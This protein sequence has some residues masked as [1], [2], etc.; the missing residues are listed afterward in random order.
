MR[1]AGSDCKAQMSGGGRALR[2][3]IAGAYSDSLASCELQQLRAAGRSCQRAQP[4]QSMA[5]TRLVT[6]AVAQSLPNSGWSKQP[7]DIFW[8]VLLCSYK[9]L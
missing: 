9:Q 2:R 6:T 1:R 5:P 3:R 4:S 8:A 7:H